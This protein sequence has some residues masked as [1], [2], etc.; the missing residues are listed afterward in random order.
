[1]EVRQPRIQW[2]SECSDTCRGG[3]GGESFRRKTSRLSSYKIHTDSSPTITA[4]SV[5]GDLGKKERG[6]IIVTDLY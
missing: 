1:M 6:Q 4:G 5:T 3:R 2:S